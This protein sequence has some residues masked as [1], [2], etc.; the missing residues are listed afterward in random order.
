MKT[1]LNLLAAGLF[2]AV[3]TA[4]L[5]QPVITQ[6]PQSCTN[7]LGSTVTFTVLATGTGP[8][9]YQWQKLSGAW[10]NLADSTA[11]NLVL[12][13][14]QSSHAGDYRAVVTNLGGAVTS[15]IA[16]LTVVASPP[17]INPTT[18]F[19]HRAV[20][21]GS[22]ASFTVSVS[23]LP[24]S[25]QWRLDGCDL[26]GK[27]LTTLA[28]TNA[29]PADEG[30]Y[31]VVVTNVIGTVTSEPARLWV[32]PPAS[33]FIKGNFTNALGRLPYFYLLPTNYSAARAYPLRFNFHGA[34]YDETG[35]ITPIGGWPGVAQYPETKTFA[36]YR[37]QQRNPVI[38]LWPTRRVG[39]PSWTESYVRQASALLDQ[40]ISQFSVDTNRIFVTGASEGVH[41]AWDV[42]ALRP[43]CFAGAGFAAGW[44]GV[45]QVAVVKDVPTWAWCAGDDEYG[46]LDNTRA[47]VRSLRQAG[48]NAIYTQYGSGGHLGGIFMGQTSPVLVDW[49]LAQRRGVT[50]TNEPLLTITGP[51]G[52]AVL[53]TGAT[54]LNLAGSAAALGQAVSQGTWENTAN[55]RTGIAL[56]SET[57]TVTGIPLAANRTNLLIVTATTTSWAL[58]YGGNTTFNDT[59]SVI[60]SPLRAALTLQG[61]NA[62]LTWTGGGPPCRVQRATDLTA[63]DWTD[64]LPDATPPVLLPLPLAGEATFY[65]IVG[66]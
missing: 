34:N 37:Q 9:T 51:T 15:R 11:T 52:Q 2:L 60:Q 53:A 47:L 50:P 36:S 41:A 62:V 24:L 12:T 48:A 14:L 29:Q 31:T 42:I 8:L 46:Q 63:G 6:Q 27:T 13:N 28:I 54:N 49:F 18:S 61:T 45:A 7:A 23:G 4:G 66:Q 44:Q 17:R 19:Q 3:A 1:K 35:I 10:S 39:E 55:S 32:V 25:Y 64:F 56:G 30:D 57:W 22:N 59:L 65:R 40:F 58:G 38:L 16:R 33:V 43:G 26:P 21:T 5:G 20:H